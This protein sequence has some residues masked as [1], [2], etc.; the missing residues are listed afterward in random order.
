MTPG[1]FFIAVP[2]VEEL[3]A[4]AVEGDGGGVPEGS[5]EWEMDGADTNVCC[6]V[7]SLS[8]PGLAIEPVSISFRGLPHFLQNLALIDT[9]VLQ[10]G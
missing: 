9:C 7:F 3:G 2:G 10:K 5:S 6:G 4:D 1:V 8:N